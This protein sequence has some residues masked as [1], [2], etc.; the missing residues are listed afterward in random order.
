MPTDWEKVLIEE[1]V[2]GDRLLEYHQRSTRWK[3]FKRD[4][5][6]DSTEVAATLA[7]LV[8]KGNARI[9]NNGVYCLTFR[10]RSLAE[11]LGF[12]PDSCFPVEVGSKVYRLAFNVSPGRCAHMAPFNVHPVTRTTQHGF[13]V[14]GDHSRHAWNCYDWP[15]TPIRYS[16]SPVLAWHVAK[17]ALENRRSS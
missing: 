17:K 4:R 3:K 13:Y 12:V 15:Y 6:P 11:E 7:G 16:T 8:A 5:R 14:D 1:L 9:Y 10:G 2:A